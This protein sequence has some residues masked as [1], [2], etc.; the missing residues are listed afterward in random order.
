[1]T[2]CIERTISFTI[3]G[4]HAILFYF[5]VKSNYFACKLCFISQLGMHT[6]LWR[7]MSPWGPKLRS[8][9]AKKAYNHRSVFLKCVNVSLPAQPQQYFFNINRCFI[10]Y[11][12]RRGNIYRTH[13][14]CHG[15]TKPFIMRLMKMKVIMLEVSRMWRHITWGLPGQLTFDICFDT[16]PPHGINSPSKRSSLLD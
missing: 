12:T 15:K 4:Q 6:N 14:L 3:Y 1:M 13:F 8:L 5:F 10:K 7:L 16:R 9:W 2:F 11:N